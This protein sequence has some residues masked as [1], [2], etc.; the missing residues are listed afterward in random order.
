MNANRIIQS[1]QA[2]ASKVTGET[3]GAF[4]QASL[5]GALQGQIILLCGK[6]SGFEA[7]KTG[8]SEREC[9]YSHDNGEFV[10]HYDIEASDDEVGYSGGVI[11][12]AIYANGMNV[13]DFIDDDTKGLIEEH[14][15]ITADQEMRES[16]YD[17]AEYRY[18]SRRDDEL[19]GAV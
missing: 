6:L 1:A 15:S 2:L 18:E 10:V 14:C 17:E 3:S 8:P 12:N 11:L 5:S 16:K 13:T 19:M 9:T 7:D 4:F